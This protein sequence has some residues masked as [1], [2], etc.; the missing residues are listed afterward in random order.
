MIITFEGPMFA[1]KTSALVKTA[2]AVKGEA[3]K[4]V[5]DSR[6]DKRDIVTHDGQRIKA[7]AIDSLLPLIH[8]E[9]PL[10]LDEAQFF[11]KIELAVLVAYRQTSKLETYLSFLDHYS[12]GEKTPIARMFDSYERA[13]PHKIKRN[14]FLAVC[15][16]CG[17]NAPLTLRL[18]DNKDTNFIGG[19][20]SYAPA[21]VRCW[22]KIK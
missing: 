6:Y 7:E 20:E 13:N 18:A 10:F 15:K 17:A 8:K 22:A 2:L 1:G 9:C 11:D 4:P 21:C 12:S 19:A 14:V 16:F 3:F 5:I